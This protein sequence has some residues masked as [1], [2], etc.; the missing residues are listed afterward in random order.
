MPDDFGAI[1]EVPIDAEFRLES[2]R[3]QRR[4][5]Q[6]DRD[7]PGLHAL[8]RHHRQTG[9]LGAA[10]DFGVNARATTI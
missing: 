8:Q 4:R 3:L 9:F 1:E 5:H 7:E 10:L 2:R 6:G